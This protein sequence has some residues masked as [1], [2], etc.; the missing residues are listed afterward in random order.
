M[1]DRW[2]AYSRIS[3]RDRI[4]LFCFPQ[5]GGTASMYRQWAEILRDINV[6]PVQLPGRESRLIE[7]PF[8]RLQ[9]L[10]ET[11]AQVMLSYLDKPFALF[12]HSMG[13]LICFE[14]A[15]YFRRLNFPVPV[16]LFVSSCRSPQIPS[17]TRSIHTLPEPL[18]LKALPDALRD[19]TQNDELMR[20]II[21]TLRA[22]FSVCEN[23]TYKP[24]DP[25]DCPISAFKGMQDY[26]ISLNDMI[27]W[28]EQTH[29]SF[30]LRKFTGNHSFLAESKLELLEAIH[31]DLMPQR[32]D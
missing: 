4:R 17:S 19:H 23:Y 28:R 2:I 29:K 32:N 6:C 7:P 3:E 18:F 8:I 27:A 16:R 21:P 13:A 9:P 10:V 1:P 11:V 30:S 31:Q 26:A 20:L 14:I 25:L 15:R 12:G 22:D 24:E 5:A